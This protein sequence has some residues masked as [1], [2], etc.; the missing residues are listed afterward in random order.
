MRR[1]AP[2]LVAKQVLTIFGRYEE[3]IAKLDGE[4]LFEQDEY[5]GALDH[6]QKALR[7][8]A[9]AGRELADEGRHK[10][11][12]DLMAKVQTKVARAD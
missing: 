3:G 12:R 1:D 7:A 6:L 5:A 2:T 9:R 11:I 4:F 10:E 8:P